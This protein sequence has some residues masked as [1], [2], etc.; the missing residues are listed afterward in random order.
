MAGIVLL[1][2]G[3]DSTVALALYLEKNSLKL[4]LT[5][6]Y[7]QRANEKEISSAQ[8]IAE[9]YDIPHRVVPLPFLQEQTH[10]ALVNRSEDLPNIGIEELDLQG[11]TTQSAS[12]VWVPN[13]NGLFMNIAAVFA[14]N[15][16]EPS[17]IITGF[18][19]E[20]AAT[21]PDNS[22]E[23]IDAMNRS[24]SYSTQEKVS[25]VSPTSNLTKAEIVREGLRLNVPF[26]H[27]W[28][29][30]ESKDRICGQCESCQRLKRALMN[31]K[32]QG[33]VSQLFGDV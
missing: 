8:K 7:G 24:F 10:S 14:E 29:C 16:G 22:L 26:E 19:R 13:R 18:N 23:F 15:M 9:Y 3:L 12:Q 21:F 33:L 31:N 28:S 27:I 5:F 6:D 32:A 1:S 25:V 20:E 4:A 11:V 2:G 30:Y 17:D